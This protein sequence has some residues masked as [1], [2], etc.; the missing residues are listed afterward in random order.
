[1]GYHSCADFFWEIKHGKLFVWKNK[2]GNINGAETGDGA[3]G[4]I[5]GEWLKY[6][7]VRR[8]MGYAVCGKGFR[9]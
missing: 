3:V 7:F 4:N 6:T 5:A 1:M 8:K 2:W 9:R